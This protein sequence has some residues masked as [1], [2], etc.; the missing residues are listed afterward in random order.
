MS[1]KKLDY[2][3]AAADLFD[4]LATQPDGVTIHEI[5]SRL[6]IAARTARLV[7]SQLRSDLG[8]GDVIA[9]VVVRDGNKQ[10]YKLS[11]DPS[12]EGDVSEWSRT[13]SKTV[14]SQLKTLSESWSA[15]ARGCE[16][17][18]VERRKSQFINKSL[19][20]LQEDVE[21]LFPETEI[22]EEVA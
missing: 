10:L 22:E 13:R 11:A 9:V 5:S 14:S 12:D 6:G 2:K 18:P 7:I 21:D 15:V 19:A 16:T 4:L 20:R 17:S 3:A 1:R 8:L